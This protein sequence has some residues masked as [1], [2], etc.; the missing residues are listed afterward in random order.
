MSN[1]ENILY[2]IIFLTTKL[3]SYNNNK[4]NGWLGGT[5]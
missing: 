3:L 5:E 2:L 4:Q 1:K